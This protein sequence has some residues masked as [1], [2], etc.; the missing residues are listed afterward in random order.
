MQKGHQIFIVCPLVQDSEAL[1]EVASVTTLFEKMKQQWPQYRIALLHGK[2]SSGEKETTLQDFRDGVYDVLVAT[3]V[4]EVG[5][6][7]PNA[8]VLMIEGSERFGLAQLH[9]LR[10]R[11]GRNDVQS[12]CFL[13]ASKP[14]TDTT[15]ERLDAFVEL[16]DGFALADIDLAL[17]GPGSLL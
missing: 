14:P 11:V 10:G 8:T 15:K 1:A 2:M 7:I 9:Q 5:I 17:R 13:F 12:Y 6:D 16:S 3:S 4:I